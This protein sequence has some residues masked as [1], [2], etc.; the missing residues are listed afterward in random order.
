MYGEAMARV[1]EFQAQ[2]G[3]LQDNI[4]SADRINF[5]GVVVCLMLGTASLPHVLSRFF[6]TPSVRE[7]RTSVAWSLLFIFILYCTAPAYAAFA[8]LEVYQ[9]VVVPGLTQLPGWFDAWSKIGLASF[10]DGQFHLDPDAVVLATPEIA[11]LPFIVAGLVAAGGLAAAL[12]SADGLLLSIANALSHDIYYRMLDPKADSKR[13]L[14]VGRLV[15][16]AAAVAAAFVASLRPAGILTVVGWAFSVAAS[17]LFPALVLGIWWKRTT[18]AGAVLG[19]FCG[20][21]VAMVYI[22]GTQHLGMAPWL[23]V[24]NIAAGLFGIPVGFIVT[25]AVSLVTKAPSKEMQDFIDSI[26]VPRGQVRLA[27]EGKSS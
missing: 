16:I 11:G 20:W 8:K 10:V 4:A 18:N 17:G 13:R 25:I 24:K 3:Q 19:M 5:F 14:I 22:M 7:A 21:A 15:M 9:Q 1:A 2:L 26:R 27:P 23:G 12:S 6:V